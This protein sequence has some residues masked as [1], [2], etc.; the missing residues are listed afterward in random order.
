MIMKKNAAFLILLCL[1]L[2]AVLVRT[3]KAHALVASQPWVEALL[4]LK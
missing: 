4:E 3:A 1:M 2:N